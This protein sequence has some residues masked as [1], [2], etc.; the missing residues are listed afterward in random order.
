[1]RLP[2]ITGWAT[3]QET[4]EIESR[5]LNG[6]RIRANIPDGWRGTITY[7]RTDGRMDRYFAFRERMFH[8]GGNL[9]PCTI[10]E[11]ITEADG[12]VSQYRYVDV[13]PTFNAGQARTNEKVEQTISWTASRR[14]LM[15]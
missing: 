12:S 2:L 4:A 8:A 14:E 10:V 6:A 1:M 13:S 5:P 15:I 9:P 7:D 11:T 3:E